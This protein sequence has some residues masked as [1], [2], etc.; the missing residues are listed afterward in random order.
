VP[1]A[2]RFSRRS[3][4]ADKLGLDLKVTH[5]SELLAEGLPEEGG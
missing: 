4:G 2:T 1:A 3:T 5:I